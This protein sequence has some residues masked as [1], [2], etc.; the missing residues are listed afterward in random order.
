[1]DDCTR[2]SCFFDTFC[3]RADA[4]GPPLSDSRDLNATSCSIQITV[5]IA[6]FCASVEAKCSFITLELIPSHCRSIS[7]GKPPNEPASSWRFCKR[8]L[9]GKPLRMA[10]IPAANEGSCWRESARKLQL[11]ASRR[12]RGTSEYPAPN[13]MNSTTY[14]DK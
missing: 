6:H 14:R 5:L 11:P 10:Q 13:D 3:S 9:T 1:M 2:C 12:F 8:E 4:S 7:V